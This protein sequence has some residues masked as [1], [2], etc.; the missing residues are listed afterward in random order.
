M[1]PA[2]WHSAHFFLHSWEPG[3]LALP[4]DPLLQPTQSRRPGNTAFRLNSTP[5]TLRAPGGCALDATSPTRA[6]RSTRGDQLDWLQP[7]KSPD[8]AQTHRE[9]K[10]NSVSEKRPPAR[11]VRGPHWQNVLPPG[12]RTHHPGPVTHSRAAW[13]HCCTTTPPVLWGPACRGHFTV[14]WATYFLICKC[15]L[16][17]GKVC[18]GAQGQRGPSGHQSR[19]GTSKP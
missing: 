16:R 5:S 2:S 6:L 13:C 15:P 9:R 7:P 19:T 18:A 11:A 3:S 8:P 12:H 17:P 10:G 14:L 1:T 4:Q